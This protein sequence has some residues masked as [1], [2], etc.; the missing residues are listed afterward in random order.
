MSEI[1]ESERHGAV[2][3]LRLNRPEA[4]DALS[5]ELLRALCAGQNAEADAFLDRRRPVW[6]HDR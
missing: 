4:L 2:A 6:R 1:V 5:D 3:L